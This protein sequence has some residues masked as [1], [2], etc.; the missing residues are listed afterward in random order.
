MR[1]QQPHIHRDREQSRTD[2]TPTLALALVVP[3]RAPLFVS[4]RLLAD[5]TGRRLAHRLY[6][7]L[8]VCAEVPALDTDPFPTPDELYTLLSAHYGELAWTEH[9]RTRM[10][11]PQE[12]TTL[13]IP[14]NAPLLITQRIT[15]ITD[16]P[17]RPCVPGS[18]AR[19]ITPSR[20]KRPRTS[21]RTARK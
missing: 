3:Q 18:T 14:D 17:C 4:D 9:V 16:G 21:T 15:H 10:P 8:A 6:L 20:W 12:V 5:P 19:R 7:P 2:A 11:A 1:C 13:L